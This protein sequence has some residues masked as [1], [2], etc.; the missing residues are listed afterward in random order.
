MRY[1]P[2]MITSFACQDTKALFDGR[3]VARF[4]NIER[5]A[6]RKL[7]QVHAAAT[8]DFLRIP[9][10]NFLE[11]LKR[12]RKGQYSIRINAQWRVCFR[13]ESGSASDVEI[14]DYH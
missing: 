12:D 9:P 3:R 5:V 6:I 7:Q 10:S 4:V 13:F 11:A 2:R 1:Y 14:V 8:L